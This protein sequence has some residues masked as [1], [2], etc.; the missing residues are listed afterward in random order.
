[1]K[2]ITLLFLAA[3]LLIFLGGCGSGNAAGMLTEQEA[4]EIALTHAGLTR[5]E[6]AFLRSEYEVDRGVPQYQVEFSRG[7]QEY[8]YHISAE[9]GQILEFSQEKQ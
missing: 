4:E 8:E 1:M 9:N 6:A 2:R 7:G 5:E 3:V